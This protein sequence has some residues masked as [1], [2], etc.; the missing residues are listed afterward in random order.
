[1]S[2]E[3]NL[4]IVR[5]LNGNMLRGSTQDFFPNRASFH[6]Q[7]GGGKPAVE[8]HCKELKAVFFVKDLKGNAAREDVR[9][10]VTGPKENVHGKKV[11]VRFKDGEI[12]CGYSLSY[13]PGRDGFFMFPADTGSNNLRIYVVASATAEI[14]LG[15]GADQLAQQAE[16]T[17][18]PNVA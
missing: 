3:T 4:V 10:Y 13:Q 16:G 6:L 1:M 18:R 7:P 14:R 17:R 2:A 11:A 15:P 12:V 5:Y 8:V 9:G